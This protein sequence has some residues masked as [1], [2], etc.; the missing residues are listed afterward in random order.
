L[1]PN[2]NDFA[3]ILSLQQEEKSPFYP[4]ANSSLIIK[5]GI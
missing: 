5:Q 2:N 3:T 4:A 1:A